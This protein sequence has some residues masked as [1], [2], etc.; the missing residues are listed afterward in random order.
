MINIKDVVTLDDNNDYI[1]ASKAD[2]DYKQYFLLVDMNNNQNI[3]F[4]Y[5]EEDEMVQITDNET[6]N[7]LLPLFYKASKEALEDELKTN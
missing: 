6:C 3:K 1:V 2:L 7:K 5:I 4:C